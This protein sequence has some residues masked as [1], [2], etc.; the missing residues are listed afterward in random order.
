MM[1]RETSKVIR[2]DD[3]GGTTLKLMV[4]LAGVTVLLISSFI[5]DIS[6]DE[7]IRKY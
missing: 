4:I 2:P 5:L 3:P 7:P 6:S 1:V